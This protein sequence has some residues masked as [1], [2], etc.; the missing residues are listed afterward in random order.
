MQMIYNSP[1]FCVVEFADATPEDGRA[2]RGFEIV[3]TLPMREKSLRQALS[4]HDC[5]PLEILV[6]GVDVDPDAL[7]RRLRPAGSQALSTVITRLGRGREAKAVAFIC[8][9]S[10][11]A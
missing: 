5:G 9:A 6:R 4:A 8:R 10:R 11:N 1:L 3:E 7:R 2:L